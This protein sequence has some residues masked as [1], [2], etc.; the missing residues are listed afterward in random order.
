MSLLWSGEINMKLLTNQKKPSPTY[1]HNFSD[2]ARNPKISKE[3]GISRPTIISCFIEGTSLSVPFY[4]KLDAGMTV[5]A[6]L[7]LPLFLFFFLNI[8]CAMEM[9]RLHGNL[10]LALW[11]I[12]S[13][14]S[15]Y[16]YVL[17]S[18]EAPMW[19]DGS[20]EDA[21]PAHDWWKDIAGIAFVSTYVRERLIDSAG[22]A[23]LD[24]SPLKKGADSLQMWESEIFGEGDIIDLVVTYSVSPWSSLAG[25]PSFRM[26]NRYYAHIWN[27]YQLPG[28]DAENAKQIAFITEHA[29]VYHLDRNCTHLQLSARQISVMELGNVRNIY[30]GRY[31]ACEKCVGKNQ[32]MQYYITEKGDCYHYSRECPGLKRTIHTVSMEE[33]AA[34]RPCSR[35]G[36]RGE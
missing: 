26:A 36:R 8:G 22:K 16:G 2:S 11:Q 1:R 9:I 12:G 29:S 25:L 6:S 24:Q 19:E 28:G 31:Q 20:P 33:A 14:L 17:D 10:Q 13:Q 34:Y 35:C 27:G 30:G 7:I 23:Y 15:V 18:G 5:E 32:V 4:K 3:D 21:D